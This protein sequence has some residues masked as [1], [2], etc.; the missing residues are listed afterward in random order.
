MEGF[1]PWTPEAANSVKGCV[2]EGVR[3]SRLKRIPL[4]PSCPTTNVGVGGGD[5]SLTHCIVRE[6][7]GAGWPLMSKERREGVNRKGGNL[8]KTGSCSATC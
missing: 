7:L 3:Q 8:I 4:F 1:V 6:T 2:K 5:E